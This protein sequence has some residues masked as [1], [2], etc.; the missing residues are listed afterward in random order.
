VELKGI[1]RPFPPLK[2]LDV[3]D[4]ISKRAV[5]AIKMDYCFVWGEEK[6]AE[7]MWLGLLDRGVKDTRIGK[8]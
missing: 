5:A 3:A 6:V 7:I 2:A 8:F 1:K 4:E